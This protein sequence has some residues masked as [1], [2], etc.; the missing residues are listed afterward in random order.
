MFTRLQTNIRLYPRLFKVYLALI[1][2]TAAYYF[3]PVA[4]TFGA[5]LVLTAVLAGIIYLW[6][7]RTPERRRIIQDM[8]A[9]FEGRDVCTIAEHFEPVENE[10][11]EEGWHT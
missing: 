5:E 11:E 9:R 6:A 10:E 4:L 7:T 1:V 2:L 3:L 8:L